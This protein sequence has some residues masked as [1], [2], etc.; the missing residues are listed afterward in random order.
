MQLVMLHGLYMHHTIMR[1]LA[2][3]L[4]N[5]G[6]QIEGFSYNSLA[7]DAG[8]L[9]ERLS[10]LSR[11]GEPQFLVGHSLGGVLAR[12]YAEQMELPEGSRIVT[13]G[14]PH[15]GAAIARRLAQWKLEGVMGNAH[16]HGL[17]TNPNDHYQG[18]AE[19][20]SLA[21][22]AGIGV[23]RLLLPN[24]ESDTDGTVLVEETRLEGFHDHIILPHSHTSMLFSSE[25]ARQTD[26]FLRQ[27]RFQQPE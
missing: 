4:S 7:I 21:G 20:G 17:L 26:L 22:N 9:F 13:L 24:E 11:P 3:Q 8:L 14:S 15:K 1:P 2:A 19:L 25:V 6:W 27:G 16:Q 12:R 23:G 5:L 10:A 18:S